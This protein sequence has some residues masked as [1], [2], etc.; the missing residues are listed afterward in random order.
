MNPT[1]FIV[2]ICFIYCE[3][4]ANLLE[5]KNNIFVKMMLL[6]SVTTLL[7][8]CYSE[9]MPEKWKNLGVPRAGIVKIYEKS[10]DNG[11]FVDYV[12]GTPIKKYLI[13][14]TLPL[15]MLAIK[16]LAMSL[17]VSSKAILAA[18]KI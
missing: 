3:F 12:R 6:A 11:L 1:N 16:Q 15:Y 7:L 13:R 5:M 17:M 14:S 8:N 9:K 18:K 10:D 2:I 4:I